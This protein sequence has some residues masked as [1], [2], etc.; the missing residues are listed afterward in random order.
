M[1]LVNLDDILNL[2]P[3]DNDDVVGPKPSYLHK[4]IAQLPQYTTDEKVIYLVP[5][6]TLIN[7]QRDSLKL[8]ALEC[9]GVDNWEGYGFAFDD[10]VREY[11]MS[12]DEDL[13]FWDV[14][15]GLIPLKFQKIGG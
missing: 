9:A 1:T 12:D 4:A 15:E 10:I 3:I 8:E 5:E 6:S 14:A 13:T 11:S 2:I 7:L